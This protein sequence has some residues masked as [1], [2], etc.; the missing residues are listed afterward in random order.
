[1]A[2]NSR[3]KLLPAILLPTLL[4]FCLAQSP[5]NRDTNLLPLLVGR[6]FCLEAAVFVDDSR[7]PDL[8]ENVFNTLRATFWAGVPGVVSNPGQIDCHT[9]DTSVPVVGAY[10]SISSRT[11]LAVGRVDVYR[12]IETGLGYANAIVWTVS[13]PFVFGQADAIAWA[14][15]APMLEAARLLAS[16]SNHLLENY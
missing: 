7:R 10:V 5:V 15:F 4:G 14:P 3:M 6:T 12:R 9:V 8:E 16:V 2:Y 11:L 1:M 13:R